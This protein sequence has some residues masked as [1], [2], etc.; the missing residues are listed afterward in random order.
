M[1]LRNSG[2]GIRRWNLN[3]ATSTSIWAIWVVHWTLLLSGVHRVLVV[4][5]TDNCGGGRGRGRGGCVD[6]VIYTA[7][8]T[9]AITGSMLRGRGLDRFLIIV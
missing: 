9:T 6:G 2:G 7:S 3:L 4:E 5:E 1:R 8:H